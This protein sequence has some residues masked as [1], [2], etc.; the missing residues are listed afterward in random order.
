MVQSGNLVYTGIVG[1]Q[2]GE[3][4]ILRRVLILGASGGVTVRRSF[5][6]AKPDTHTRE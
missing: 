6:A 3:L 5:Y 1:I 2:W 4:G